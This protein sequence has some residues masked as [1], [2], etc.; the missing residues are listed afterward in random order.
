MSSSP[1]GDYFHKARSVSASVL[2]IAAVVA[3]VGSLLDWVVVADTPPEVPANQMHR[4][5][6]FSGTELGDGYVVIGAAVVVIVAAFFLVL[7]GGSGFAWLAFVGCIVIGGIAISD[8]RGVAE[9]HLDLEGIGS[10]PSP[11]VGLTLVAAAGFVGLVAAVAAI[12]AS[13]KTGSG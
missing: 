7:R 4:L 8:Y 10:S 3:I 12:A 2:F 13:P 9:L 11:G 5:P 1:T 6:P